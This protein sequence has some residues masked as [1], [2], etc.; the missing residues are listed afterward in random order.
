M[1][2]VAEIEDEVTLLMAAQKQP[3]NLT[4]YINMEIEVNDIDETEDHPKPSCVWTTIATAGR[5]LAMK[6]C[7]R[8]HADIVI[9]FKDSGNVVL[10]DIILVM[11]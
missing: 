11:L 3:T 10:I 1:A 9:Q 5:I 8:D 6:H 7:P 4:A 2:R